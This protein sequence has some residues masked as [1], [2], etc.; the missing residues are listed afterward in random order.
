VHRCLVS[1]PPGAASRNDKR[2][3]SRRRR[4]IETTACDFFKTDWC[5]MRRVTARARHLASLSF[6][7]LTEQHAKRLT[8]NRFLMFFRDPRMFG[9]VF[10]TSFVTGARDPAF[11]KRMAVVFGKKT[12]TECG[13]QQ[14]ANG[15][16]SGA[17]TAR[18]VETHSSRSQTIQSL[19]LRENNSMLKG[20]K[21]PVSGKKVG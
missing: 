2:Q 3:D 8:S 9:P 17:T 11:V 7:K 6:R 19:R 20:E 13:T 12:K 15:W 16:R 10:A 14:F 18:S 1:G 21:L 5:Q 4:A